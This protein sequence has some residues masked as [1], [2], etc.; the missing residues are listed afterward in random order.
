MRVESD[1]S[2]QNYKLKVFATESTYFIDSFNLISN[3]VS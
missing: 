3:Q 1:E 2:F